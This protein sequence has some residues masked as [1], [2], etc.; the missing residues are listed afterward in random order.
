MEKKKDKFI[1]L[2]VT[3]EEAYIY[4]EKAVPLYHRQ[5]FPIPP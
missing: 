1:K 2:R 4:K 5:L 3:S